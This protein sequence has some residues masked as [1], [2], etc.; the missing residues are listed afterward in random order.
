V[1]GPGR[2]VRAHVLKRAV[3]AA[4][5]SALALPATAAAAPDD[6]RRGIALAKQGRCDDAIPLLSRAETQRSRP[7]T[8]EALARCLERKKQLVAAL[9]M[10]EW[11]AAQEREPDWTMA[12]FFARDRAR[13]K[14]KELGRR[15]P[16]LQ[17]LW[18]A[19]PTPTIEI[20]GETLADP[21]APHRADPGVAIAIVAKAPGCEPFADTVTLSEGESHELHLELT[22][23]RQKAPAPD[24]EP[25]EDDEPAEPDLWVG[26]RF[27]GIVIPQFLMSAF[28]DGGTTVLVPGGALTVTKTTGGPDLI[29]SVGWAGYFAGDMPWKG[30]D[31]ADTE[32][33]LVDADLQSLVV[34]LDL[35]WSFPIDDAERWRF[36][37]GGGIGLGI[38][39]YGALNR[40]QA[41]PPDGEP[42][43]PYGYAKCE[44]PN[45][46]PGTFRYCNALDKD[47]D[48]YDG[49]E[50][51]TWFQGG[52]RPLVYPWLALPQLEMEWRPGD[53]VALALE[54]ATSI[55]G[56]LFGLGVRGAP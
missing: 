44:G 2:E 48:H 34:A 40:T 24:P 19:G 1:Q 51:P 53:R 33:E 38:M 39:Y 16:T 29:F 55:S 50:E 22:C 6:A 30:R 9:E 4:L 5:A 47:F 23:R 17:L 42:G 21:G 36:R 26:A 54:L 37:I 49:Y 52:S 41:Y 31:D 43:D 20:D 45:D 28:G 18:G 7:T 8:G 32:W 27:R 25:V 12:D 3:A 13:R 56:F 35:M 11:V 15:V 46:P 10:Y 14:K